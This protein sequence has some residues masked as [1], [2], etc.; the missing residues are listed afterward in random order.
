MPDILSSECRNTDERGSSPA[1]APRSAPA[2]VWRLPLVREIA[3]ILLIK[4]VLLFSIKAIWF[5]APT[6]PVDGV[7]Q[8]AGHL[9]GSKPSTPNLPAPEETPR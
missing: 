9:L 3:A 7:A 6:I 2:S 5:S 8:V 1:Q 4:L